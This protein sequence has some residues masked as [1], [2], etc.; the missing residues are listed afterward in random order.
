MSSEASTE[1]SMKAHR[2]FIR[3]Q[4]PEIQGFLFAFLYTTTVA[5]SSEGKRLHRSKQPTP[6]QTTVN[7]LQKFKISQIFFQIQLP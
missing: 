4:R 3:Q 1:S 7:R 5:W 2:T 6:N